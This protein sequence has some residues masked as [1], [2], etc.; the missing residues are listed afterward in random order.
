MSTR[1]YWLNTFRP[2]TWQEFLD[3]GAQI[4]GFNKHR[5][6]SIQSI[7]ISDYLLCYMAGVSRWVG[8][9]EVTSKPYED[10]TPIWKEDVFSFRLRVKPVICL[11]QETGV[12]MIQLKDY[13]SIFK[14]S[15]NPRAWVGYLRGAPKR[16]NAA[17]AKI[18]IYALREAQVNPT[19]YPVTRRKDG[20]LPRPALKKS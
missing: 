9:L 17:D 11:T 15:T 5:Q 7:Q 16:W 6:H 13:L 1:N 2:E 10:D 14:K 18:I 8:I 4:T 20:R 3:S 19:F 12:P